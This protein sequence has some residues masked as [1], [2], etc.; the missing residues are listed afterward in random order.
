MVNVPW[1]HDCDR[2]E[3]LCECSPEQDLQD[4]HAGVVAGL[5]AEIT[6]VKAE[7]ASA[8]LALEGER[9]E[10]AKFVKKLQTALMFWMP[11]V[12][13]ATDTGLER[14]AGDDAF[15]LVGFDIPEPKT[16][17]GDDILARAEA[18]EAEVARLRE[19]LE[20][21]AAAITRYDAE[22]DD[23]SGS[24][25]REPDE[26]KVTFLGWLGDYFDM[27]TLGDLRRARTALS[28]SEHI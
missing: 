14:S 3:G 25:A 15:L 23:K 19:A 17:W 20:P 11:G 24:Q 9:D 7:A 26:E 4:Y 2:P 28:S 5:M 22:W 6:R 21:F 18:A 27:V 16:C 13:E 12:R 8:L 10:S 1:C